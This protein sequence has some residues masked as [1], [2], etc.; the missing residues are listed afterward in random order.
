[1]SYLN[2]Q[3]DMYLVYEFKKDKVGWGEEDINIV[4]K[5]SL[6][7]SDPYGIKCN[8]GLFASDEWWR[9]VENGTILT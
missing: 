9:N 8:H 1:M 2:I 7:E 3:D 5:L 4:R 6:D